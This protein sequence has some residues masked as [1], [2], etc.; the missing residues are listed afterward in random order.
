MQRRDDLDGDLDLGGPVDVGGA[1]QVGTG[2]TTLG[3]LQSENWAVLY[4]CQGEPVFRNL[5]PPS[6]TQ[7]AIGEK[8]HGNTWAILKHCRGFVNAV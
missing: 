4:R 5:E 2:V 1:T 7:V 8:A 6:E 3:W